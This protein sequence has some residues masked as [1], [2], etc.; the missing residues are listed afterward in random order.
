MVGCFREIH[1][2]FTYKHWIDYLRILPDAPMPVVVLELIGIGPSQVD[3]LN[4]KCSK[5]GIPMRL[6]LVERGRQNGRQARTAEYQKSHYKLY[7]VE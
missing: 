3:S 4:L 5:N 7:H 1:R 6:K 2:S